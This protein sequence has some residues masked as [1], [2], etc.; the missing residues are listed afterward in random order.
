MTCKGNQVFSIGYFVSL[1]QMRSAD[2]A[3][4]ERI[5]NVMHWNTQNTLLFN[6]GKIS[7]HFSFFETFLEDRT[8]YVPVFGQLWI[9]QRISQLIKSNYE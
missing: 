7:F 2:G 4:R 5:E 6:P 9:N 3:L 1:V 8:S